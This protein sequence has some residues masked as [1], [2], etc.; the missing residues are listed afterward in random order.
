[1]KQGSSL[2]R[3][4]SEAIGAFVLI[5]FVSFVLAMFQGT[6]IKEWFNPGLDVRI[7]L[8]EEGLFGLFEG[9]RPRYRNIQAHFHGGLG[10]LHV[11]REAVHYALAYARVS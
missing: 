10:H 11:A 5:A 9:H 3:Y 4:A 7:V 6:R 2:H 1:M 8:P